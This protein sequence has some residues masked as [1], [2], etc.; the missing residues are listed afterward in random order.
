MP[1]DILMREVEV[2]IP[3][4]IPD[5]PLRLTPTDVTQFVRLEQCER[6]LRFRLAERAGLD[7]MEPHGVVP[8]RMTPL[9]SLSGHEFEVRVEASIAGKFRTVHYAA[10]SAQAHNRADN[11]REVVE[12]AR[13][14]GPGEA[15]VLL[16]PRLEAELEGW[17]LRGDVDLLSLSGGYCQLSLT[18]ISQAAGFS[19]F[20]PSTKMTPWMI[21]GRS[22]EP[23]NERHLFDAD[24]ISL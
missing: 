13:N 24:S 15:V 8:Q 1:G 7:F 20:T 11:N 12:E 6:Y 4:L 18:G 3:V 22:F 21:S 16:Q 2:T 17:R 10:L 5:R 19:C 14:L 9:L 23:F